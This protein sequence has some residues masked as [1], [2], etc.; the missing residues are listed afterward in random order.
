MKVSRSAQTCALGAAIFGAI[1]G[2][3]Y[4]NAQEAQKKM[5]GVKKKVF[6]PSKERGAYDE[7]YPLYKS[8]HDS[9]GLPERQDSQCRVMKDL[10]AVRDRVRKG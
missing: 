6:H 1:V 5:T 7:L 9:F 2:G 8:L 4:A 3:V 10:I